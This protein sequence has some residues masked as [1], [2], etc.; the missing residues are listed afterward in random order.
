M[1]NTINQIQ[2]E[3]EKQN[4]KF[5]A[6]NHSPIEWMA[7][8][9]EEVGEASQAAVDWHFKYPSKTKDEV[10]D[11]NEIQT[12]RLQFYKTELIQVAALA[13]QMVESLNRNELA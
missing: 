4:K 10:E 8:L 6:Q 1:Q 5:G 13:I 11:F 9:M 7:I 3:I 12:Q 2:A